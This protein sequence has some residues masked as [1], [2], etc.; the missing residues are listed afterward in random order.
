MNLW[1]ISTVVVLAVAVVFLVVCILATIFGILK[2]LSTIKSHVARIQEDQLAPLLA[3]TVEL[4]ATI[5]NL[6]SDINGKRND[7]L[8]VIQSV[9]NIGIN[10]LDINRSAENFTLS[11]IR[12]AENNQQRKA[13]TEHWTNVA[14]GL[15]NRNA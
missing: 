15:L 11:A 2:I 13:Q 7:V 9:E 4:N 12:K 10:V 5:G 1:L 14:M 8:S 6:Q 3:K